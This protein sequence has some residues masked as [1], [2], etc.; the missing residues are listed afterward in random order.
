[1]NGQPK[2]EPKNQPE[3][4]VSHR[5]EQLLSV[6]HRRSGHRWLMMASMIGSDV[7]SVALAWLIGMGAR[8]LIL[9]PLDYPRYLRCWPLLGLWVVTFGVM[10]LYR[11]AGLT[12]RIFVTPVEELR[13]TTV[14]TTWAFLTVVVVMY[15]AHGSLFFSRLILPVSWLLALVFVP[16]GRA[17]LR[18]VFARRPWW[19]TEVVVM[20]SGRSA[21]R[22][23][24]TLQNQP[25]L[26]LKPV[27]VL[28]DT[29][30]VADVRGVPV[31]GGLERAPE[32]G[33]QLQIRYCIVALDEDSNKQLFDI[34]QKYGDAFQHMMIIPQ[35]GG[36]ASLWIVARDVGG[37]LGLE[38]RH[39]LLIP[40]N[41]WLKRALDLAVAIPA[42]VLTT[43]LTL[44]AMGFIRLISGRPVLYQQERIG[45]GGQIIR[46]RKLRTM[47]VDAEKRL[48]EL[49]ERDPAARAEWTRYMKLRNDPRIL[50]G[51]RLLRRYSIDELP[52]LWNVIVGEM[53]LVGPRPLPKYHLDSFPP[54]FRLLRQQVLPGLTGLWQ[55]SARSEGDLEVQE[56]LDTYYI[57]N[58]SVWLDLYLLARSVRVVLSGR[59]AY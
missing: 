31:L 35:L 54:E 29:P 7:I 42:I 51:G 3:I 28:T 10:G 5:H 59:G 6:K 13:R 56:H 12:A 14:G 47:H 23:I 15:G 44:L 8:E 20:G 2:Q 4:A 41:R 18:G 45:R 30:G 19:G 53:S 49:L 27:A 36:L 55:V 58:W 22:V 48:A 38:I 21:H 17:I 43:P 11:G 16:C 39:N 52:Q 57:R 9:G 34:H 37:L 46:I 24:R 32:V 50:P 1:M 25:E 33:R 40:T 26:G